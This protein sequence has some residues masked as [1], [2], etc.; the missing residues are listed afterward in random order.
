MLL[1]HVKLVDKFLLVEKE[2]STINLG[3]FRGQMCVLSS[4]YQTFFSY[5]L[6]YKTNNKNGLFLG[7]GKRGIGSIMSGRHGGQRP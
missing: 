4:H 1:S 6:V 3:A 2:N 5:L 7:W